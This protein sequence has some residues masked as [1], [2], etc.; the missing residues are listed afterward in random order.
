MRE[1]LFRGKQ[2]NTDV[3]LVGDL[4]QWSEHKKGICDRAL[5]TTLEVD[6]ETV[7]Q[8]TGLYDKDGKKIFEGDIIA[9]CWQEKEYIQGVV[10]YGNFNCTCCNGVYGW[11]FNGGD[12]REAFD[13]EKGGEYG[14][15]IKGNIYDNPE[16][17]GSD[18][19]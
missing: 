5:K 3:W 9:S 7:G 11:F 12:I 16:L 17:L 4:R 2:K 8:F 15:Y 18:R 6:P 10:E 1:I 14:I 13:D 19:R